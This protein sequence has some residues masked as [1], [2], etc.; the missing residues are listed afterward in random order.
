MYSGG[1]GEG[2]GDQGER[3]LERGRKE[4]DEVQGGFSEAKPVGEVGGYEVAEDV[5]L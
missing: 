5:R 1:L 2:D 3:L 4:D